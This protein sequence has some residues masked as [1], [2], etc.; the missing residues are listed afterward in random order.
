MH[1]LV[2]GGAGF[3]GSHLVEYHLKKGDTVHAID[4][5]SSGSE[6]N[7]TDFISHPNFKFKRTDI[8]H[9]ENMQEAVARADRIYHMA[10][11]VGVYKV[12]EE[13]DRVLNVNI[14]GF[15]KLL[16]AIQDSHVNP[17]VIVA[18]SSEV[19][20][21]NKEPTLKEDANLMIQASARNRLHYAVS[22]LAD[23][24]FAIA[25]HK[26]F[27]IPITIIRLFNT[28]G[29]R[30]VGRYGMVVP[31]FINQA[32]SNTPITVFGKGEQT[33]SF[34]DVRDTVTILDLLA[35]NEKAVGEPINVG[36]D[37]EIAIKD[38]AALVKKLAN[39]DSKIE[40]VP[41]Q[42]AYGEAYVDIQRRKPDLNKLLSYINFKH[43]WTLEDSISNLIGIR[44]K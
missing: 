12:L 24:S 39:S 38:L 33:R 16:Q 25:F 21:Q 1:I 31:R 36:N 2:S 15:Q 11:V 9:W 26:K 7:I 29:P 34:C 41:Y 35:Q 44:S 30:Q 14:L 6:S 43:Q 42:E 28:I 17:R 3:I 5:L 4:D 8:L 19:Y 32:I 37:R 20:G 23:E 18:S 22:K 10:A 13:P 27:A 40:Y